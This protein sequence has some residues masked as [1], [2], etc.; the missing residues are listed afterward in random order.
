M[1]ERSSTTGALDLG[2][3]LARARER[4]PA[5]RVG[6]GHRGDRPGRARH[7]ARRRVGEIVH[8]RR[9]RRLRAPRSSASAATRP[10]CCRSAS[11]PASAPTRVVA[12]T[13]RPLADPRAATALLGRVLDGL[14]EP[15]RRRRR[16]PATARAVGRR[17]RRRPIRFARRRVTEPLPPG[18]RALDALLTLGEGQ[19]VGLFAGSGRRQVDAARADR[20]PHRGRRDRHRAWS[21]SAAARCASSSTSRSAPGAARARSSC[22]RPATRRRSCACESALVATAIA[23]YFRDRGR[24]RAASARLAD[25]RRARPARGRPGRRRAARAPRL[26]AERV[27]AAAAPARAHRQR[28]SAARSPR[29]TPCSSPAATWTSRSPTRCAASSTATSCSSR[30]SRARDHLPADRRAARRCRA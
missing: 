24:A 10:C 13:G 18:V 3:A 15:D 21:A 9:G 11:P 25:A 28:T 20:A 2:Q 7:R 8:D 12:P 6:P 30:D 4:G 1:P 29:S 26:P 19:R 17:S 14:G 23:E 5:P 27:R 16:S 22:A